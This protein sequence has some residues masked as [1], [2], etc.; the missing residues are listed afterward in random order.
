MNHELLIPAGNME[1][2]YQAVYNGADAVYV[3]GLNFGARKF[4]KNFTK[5]ELVE[6]IN[7]CH[8]YGVRIYV[9]MNTLIKDNEVDEFIEQAR[10]L[11][12]NGV[13]ALIVQDFGMICLL[14]RK[15]PNLEIHASTQAN[16]SSKETCKL[17]YDLGVKRVVFSRELSIDEIKSID[18]PI[19]KEAFIHGALCV[20]YSGCC[21]MSS[22]L[23]GRSGNRGECAG[24]CRLPYSL[25]KKDIIIQNNKYLLSMKE[26][27]TSSRIN[28]LLQSDIYSFKVEGRMKSPLYVAFITRFYRKLIDGEKIDLEYETDCLKIIFNREFTIGHIFHENGISLINNKTPNHIGLKIGK[29]KPKNDKILIE[30]D[31]NRKLCQ[32]DAVRFLNSKKGMIINFLYDKKMNL[33]NSSSDICYIDNKVDLT[34]EDVLMKTQSTELERIYNDSEYYKKIGISF[35][36]I[37]KSGC[38]LEVLVTD[39]VNN[40]TQYGDIVAD[41]I[42]MP[43]RKDNFIKQLSKVGDTVYKVNNIDVSID[44]NIFVQLREIN[45]LRRNLLDKLSEKRMENKAKFLENDFHFFKNN[46]KLFDKSKLVCSV[47]TEEQLEACINNKVDR[48]YVRNYDLYNKYKNN[49]NVYLFLDRCCYQYG[50]YKNEKVL[51]SDIFDYNN[52]YAYG[53]YSLNVMNIYSAY[54]LNYFGLKCIP[55]SVELTIDEVKSLINLY[56]EK[57]GSGLFEVLIYGRVENMIIDGN[58]LD[59]DENFN[60]YSLIDGKNRVFPVYYDGK[61]THIYNYENKNLLFDHLFVNRL[62]FYD[63][64]YDEVLNILNKF[65]I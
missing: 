60:I 30:L 24:S 59:I 36:V 53:N 18:V 57:F 49:S 39:G 54:F 51:V 33:C 12:K 1:C 19:E 26:L 27:N 6:A 35:K 9:T 37:A 45:E 7:F 13:D 28:D 3:S 10:F 63:E 55:L 48:I 17:F 65:N 56:N 15:F 44:D 62:D 22:M 8:L 47:V 32:F 20:C 46:D 61:N 52:Y 41:A 31:K 16:N 38:K 29:V 2:L 34:D 4:A 58:I 42:S 64:K 25:M 50:S 43:T 11:H 21:L 40:I 5:D 23:G 14:R